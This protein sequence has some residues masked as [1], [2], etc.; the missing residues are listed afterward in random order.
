[1][2]VPTFAGDGLTDTLAAR[3]TLRQQLRSML[4]NSALK[5][6]GYCYLLYADDPDQNGW[7]IP[8][9]GQLSD[10][11]GSSGLSTGAWKLDNVN[12]AMVGHRRTH[13]EARNIWMKNLTLGLSYRDTLRLL[14][15]T[16]F[17]SLA[18]NGS[19]GAIGIT[20]F[21]AGTSQAADTV[22][23]VMV[24]LVLQLAGRDGGASSLSVGPPGYSPLPDLSCVSYERL[25]ASWGLSDVIVYDRRGDLS[26]PT[27]GPSSDW[28]E[29]YGPDFPWNWLTAGQ[30]MDAPVLDNGLVRVRYS[31]TPLPGFSVDMWNGA[32]YVEQGKLTVVRNPSGGGGGD[33]NTLVSAGLHL[34]NGYTSDRAILA[35]VMSVSSQP[36]SRERVFI[37]MSRGQPGITFE[38]YPA[39]QPSGAASDVVFEWAMAV[40][41]TNDSI[42]KIDSVTQASATLG[43]AAPAGVTT[44]TAGGGLWFANP[45]GAASFAS[46]ENEIAILR[47]SAVATL[48]AF[49]TNI[50]VVQAA[51][52]YVNLLSP[53]GFGYS[54]QTNG[55]D[56]NSQNS[57]GYLSIDIGFSPT[58]AQQVMEA[59][60]MILGSGTTAP[61]TADAS[62]GQTTYATRTSSAVHVSQT[63]WPNGQ[64]G[65]YR[66]FARCKCTA[67]QMSINAKTAETTGTVRTLAGAATPVYSWVDLGEVLVG[68]NTDTLLIDAWVSGGSGGVYV[69]RIEAYLMTERISPARYTGARDFGQSV[70]YDSR[71]LGAVVSR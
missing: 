49:Q 25:E 7:Y 70:L 65:V 13:R 63:A 54:Y 67:T 20:T 19:A 29:V 26:D 12:W 1:V 10:I 33:C 50:A 57:A 45:F 24:P 47:C 16:D 46:S 51:N 21:P 69:D 41:D 38:C 62:N 27:T 36:Y 42:I 53:S 6:Q 18:N 55:L 34:D 66:I 39:P 56:I 8:D 58:V 11:D 3:L 43:P 60:S 40:Q 31:P 9:Q 44:A 30:P 17:A 4:N 2:T 71:A 14:Y 23:G 48:T 68:T 28:V 32:A 61:H 5:L 15:S 22:T 59:E 35:A 52:T 64:P 37:T